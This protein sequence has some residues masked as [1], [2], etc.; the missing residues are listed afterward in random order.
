MVDNSQGTGLSPSSSIPCAQKSPE[1]QTSPSSTGMSAH[2][3]NLHNTLHENIVQGQHPAANQQAFKQSPVAPQQQSPLLHT[4]A[5]G[6][7]AAP[8]QQGQP[9]FIQPMVSPQGQPSRQPRQPSQFIQA[10]N[11]SAHPFIAAAEAQQTNTVPN[12]QEPKVPKYVD[13]KGVKN[14]GPDGHLCFCCRQP[15]HL[16]KD[17]P[18]GLYCSCCDT[19]GDTPVKCL[20]K[21][22][23]QQKEMHESV[24]WQPEERCENWK[25]VQDQPQYLN[26][27]NKCL[28]CTGD[29]R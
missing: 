8:V 10:F 29:H 17:C 12:I 11:L 2:S 27:E 26:P 25:K 13:G 5:P 19:R 7:H 28:H 14:G 23:Q 1:Q 9:Q 4:P 24:N 20:N 22:S 18:L 3:N 21:K 15:G 6:S 16:K